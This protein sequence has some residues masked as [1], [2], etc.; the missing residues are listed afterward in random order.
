M[1][2]R[3]S[4]RTLNGERAPAA[5]GCV[6]RGEGALARGRGGRESTVQ[7]FAPPVMFALQSAVLAS[8]LVVGSAL[9]AAPYDS[10]GNLQTDF[11]DAKAVAPA[12]RV[13]DAHLKVCGLSQSRAVV[14]LPLAL[15]RRSLSVSLSVSLCTCVRVWVCG[16]GCGC[17]CGWVRGSTGVLVLSLRV[18]RSRHPRAAPGSSQHD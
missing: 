15:S 7:A 12:T 8:G 14:V 2:A 10:E 4:G 9:P 17:G 5:R 11:Y 16:C 6:Q 18:F 1:H 13:D 3:A